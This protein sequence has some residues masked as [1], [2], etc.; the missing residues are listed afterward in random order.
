L[1]EKSLVIGWK[2]DEK[3]TIKKNGKYPSRKQA[4]GR[5]SDGT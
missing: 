4:S 3:I 5:L 1:P 2:I